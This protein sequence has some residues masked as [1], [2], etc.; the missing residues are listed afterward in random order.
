MNIKKVVLN[1]HHF[2]YFNFVNQMSDVLSL[3]EHPLQNN[4]RVVVFL[5]QPKY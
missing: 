3:E 2:C 5:K 4:F 1:K